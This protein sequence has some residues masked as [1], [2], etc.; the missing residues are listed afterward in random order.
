MNFLYSKTPEN[1]NKI[2]AVGGDK[3]GKL[4]LQ[5]QMPLEAETDDWLYSLNYDDVTSNWKRQMLLQFLEERQNTASETLK[6]RR[7]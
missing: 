3:N 6:E 5:R 7:D 2:S 1:F 4:A